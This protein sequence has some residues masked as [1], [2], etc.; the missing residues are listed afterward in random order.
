MDTGIAGIGTSVGKVP[1][2]HWKEAF[3]GKG[4]LLLTIG[5]RGG[6]HAG[7]LVCKLARQT[8]VYCLRALPLRNPRVIECNG[9]AKNAEVVP[10]SLGG[11]KVSTPQTSPGMCTDMPLGG[12]CDLL[13]LCLIIY[14]TDSQR[15]RS[16]W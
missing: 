3:T 8:A 14:Y 5:R 11:C 12:D 7:I 1:H 10:R 4:M 2:N 13:S 9:Q 16:R 15:Q 6:N